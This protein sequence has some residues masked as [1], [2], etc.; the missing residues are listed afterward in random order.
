MDINVAFG[1]EGI[2]SFKA[3]NAVTG[4]ERDLDG[5]IS[6]E[7]PNMVVDS[8]LN[9]LGSET[10]TLARYCKVGTSSSPV[11]ASQTALGNEVASTQT[12]QAQS[13]GCQATAPYFSWGRITFRF[14]QGAAAGNLTEVGI[15]DNNNA[16]FSRALI[17]DSGGNPTTL[18]ILSDEYLD[19][20]YE[21]RFYQETADQNFVVTLYGVDYD[22][23][24]RPANI[25]GVFT[26]PGGIITSYFYSHITYYYTTQYYYYNGVIGPITGQ[27]SGSSDSNYTGYGTYVNGSLEKNFILSLGLNNGNLAGGIK[28]VY[29]KTHKADWQLQFTPAI[30]KDNFKTLVLNIYVSWARYTP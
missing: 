9:A 2:Y 8:G 29:I 7:S 26:N 16:L 6:D 24:A 23:L 22:V 11:L 13:G 14:G 5:I 18:T 25:T 4:V 28:S 17:L 1:V 21:L 3:V 12:V 20:T 30:P 15:S 19:V 10:N 27:P